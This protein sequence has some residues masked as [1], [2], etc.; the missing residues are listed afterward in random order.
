MY[1]EYCPHYKQKTPDFFREKISC[2]HVFTDTP[3]NFIVMIPLSLTLWHA[4]YS[5]THPDEY[6]F[7]IHLLEV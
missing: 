2:T 1:V 4:C 3:L 7:K 6:I 5:F